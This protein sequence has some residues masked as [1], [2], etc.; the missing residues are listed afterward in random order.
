MT[1]VHGSG[2]IL[3]V[4]GIQ[5]PQVLDTLSAHAD[6]AVLIV[7]DRQVPDGARLTVTTGEHWPK[8]IQYLGWGVIDHRLVWAVRWTPD[9]RDAAGTITLPQHWDPGEQMPGPFAR[10]SKWKAYQNNASTDINVEGLDTPAP[11]TPVEGMDSEGMDTVD[12]YRNPFAR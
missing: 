12:G 6:E 11:A 3:P 7:S 5:H 1:T 10:P 8:Q 2:V 9:D 4:Y